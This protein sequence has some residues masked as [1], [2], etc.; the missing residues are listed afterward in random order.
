MP[1][2][3]ELWFAQFRI[4]QAFFSPVH[5]PPKLVLIIGGRN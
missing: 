3:F 4:M 5:T 1:I 2:F